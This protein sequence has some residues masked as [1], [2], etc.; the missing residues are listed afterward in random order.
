[1]P[2]FATGSHSA[3]LIPVFAYGPGAEKFMGIYQNTEIFHKMVEGI[4]GL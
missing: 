1:G 4:N 2:A 3:T